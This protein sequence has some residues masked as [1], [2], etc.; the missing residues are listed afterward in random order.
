VNKGFLAAAASHP[1]L[2]EP[3]LPTSQHQL[4]GETLSQKF[5]WGGSAGLAQQRLEQRENL[6]RK[7]EL[8]VGKKIELALTSLFLQRQSS[9]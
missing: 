4:L 6:N 1:Y 5:S 7:A 2:P 3:T 8:Q 9:P